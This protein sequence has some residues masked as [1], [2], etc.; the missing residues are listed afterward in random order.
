MA[1]GSIQWSPDKTGTPNNE[2]K[3]TLEEIRQVVT[4]WDEARSLANSQGQA[5]DVATFA[6]LEIR[7]IFGGTTDRQV[8][9]AAMQR[10]LAEAKASRG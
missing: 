7:A 5:L 1:M 4:N 10:F 2:P 3:P 8:Y 6:L 9:Q